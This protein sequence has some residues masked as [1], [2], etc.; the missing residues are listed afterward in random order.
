MEGLNRLGGCEPGWGMAP[1]RPQLCPLLLLAP[2]LAARHC[3]VS[4]ACKNSCCLAST[5]SIT[6]KQ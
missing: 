2:G 4:S 5:I 1:V 6:F 3:K